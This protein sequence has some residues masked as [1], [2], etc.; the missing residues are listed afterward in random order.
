MASLT[1]HVLSKL[2]NG[3]FGNVYSVRCDSSGKEY[4]L[5]RVKVV[6]F[7]A[8]D[9]RVYTFK[10]TPIDSKQSREVQTNLALQSAL[11]APS[12]VPRLYHQFYTQSSSGVYNNMIFEKFGTSLQTYLNRRES[13][14]FEARNLEARQLC[15]GLLRALAFV[16]SKN[17]MHRDLKPANILVDSELNLK[18]CD[19]GSGKLYVPGTESTPYITSRIYR[20][21]ELLFGS[22]SYGVAVDLWAAGCVITEIFTGKTLFYPSVDYDHAQ[23]VDIISVCGVPTREEL[24]A[25]NIPADCGASIRDIEAHFPSRYPTTD[26]ELEKKLQRCGCPPLAVNLIKSL[27]RYN[28]SDRMTANNALKHPYFQRHG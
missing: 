1:Y 21:P 12:Y 25:M 23:V 17:I 9:N 15:A 10:R 8:D 16:H 11:S 2:G 28:P 4:A 26:K 22:R 13:T 3:T 18:I 5:K 27:L 7:G 19:W 24:S 20:A 6:W 14:C